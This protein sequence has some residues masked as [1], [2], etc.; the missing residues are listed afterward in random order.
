MTTKNKKSTADSKQVKADEIDVEKTTLTTVNTNALEVNLTRVD[1]YCAAFQANVSALI[2]LVVL[3]LLTTFCSGFAL[4]NLCISLLTLAALT[5]NTALPS[6]AY[7]IRLLHVCALMCASPFA[8]LAFLELESADVTPENATLAT[9]RSLAYTTSS[10]A[11]AAAGLTHALWPTRHATK[12]VQIARYFVA[13]GAFIM[14]TIHVPEGNIDTRAPLSTPPSLEVTLAHCAR[15]VAFWTVGTMS[16]LATLSQKAIM[17]ESYAN[18]VTRK[19]LESAVWTLV[20]PLPT[21]ALAAVQMLILG[22]RRTG[23]GG[24]WFDNH[25]LVV[26]SS[27]VTTILSGKRPSKQPTSP[28]PPLAPASTTPPSDTGVAVVSPTPSP[29]PLQQAAPLAA[30]PSLP[31]QSDR[32]HVY[33]APTELTSLLREQHHM[34][35]TLNTAPAADTPATESMRRLAAVLR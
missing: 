16:A 6:P 32:F 15:F 31:T 18:S 23:S 28:P 2:A 33:I 26:D 21:L 4:R 7:A 5:R 27:A 22:L 10:I 30:H 19:A 12:D 13:V 8:L 9:I 20:V 3:L 35:D 34:I 29:P 25:R 17:D 24:V 1:L 11:L 14:M